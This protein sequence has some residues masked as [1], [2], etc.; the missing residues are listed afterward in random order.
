VLLSAG[1]TFATYERQAVVAC[2]AGASGVMAGRAIWKEAATLSGQA[3]RTFL[4]ETAAA[5]L[6]RLTA[7]CQSHGRPWTAFYPDLAQT[8]AEGWYATY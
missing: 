2:Q 3:R 8:A 4:Q 5:R 1:V 6:R 7:V